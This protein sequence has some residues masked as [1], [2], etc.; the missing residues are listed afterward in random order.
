M[1]GESTVVVINCFQATNICLLK[2]LKAL[3]YLIVLCQ[4]TMYFSIE[5]KGKPWTIEKAWVSSN[6]LEFASVLCI[7]LHKQHHNL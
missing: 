1:L 2:I 3:T 4:D 7:L 5:K 6:S